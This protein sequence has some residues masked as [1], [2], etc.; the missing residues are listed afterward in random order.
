MKPLGNELSLFSLPNL[1]KECWRLRFNFF[2][3]DKLLE[4]RDAGPLSAD[5]WF[6]TT[7]GDSEL[8]ETTA[9]FPLE[10]GT[11]SHTHEC[12]EQYTV[13]EFIGEVVAKPFQQV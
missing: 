7:T 8:L 5:G 12:K 2:T 6:D 1:L 10:T 11:K 9:T 13:F 4:R 3:V